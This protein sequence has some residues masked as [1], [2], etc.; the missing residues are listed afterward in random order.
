M[1]TY[2]EYIEKVI[3]IHCPPPPQARLKQSS[4][5]DHRG[6]S[7]L[8]ALRALGYVVIVDRGPNKGFSRDG[9]GETLM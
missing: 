1:G 4:T 3:G 6:L 9:F 2:R 5:V 8:E 7:K